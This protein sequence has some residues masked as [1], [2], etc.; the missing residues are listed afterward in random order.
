[1]VAQP[2]KLWLVCKSVNLLLEVRVDKT[3]NRFDR[4]KHR[5]H[6]EQDR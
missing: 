4:N 6:T 1:M 2:D 5:T 3:R